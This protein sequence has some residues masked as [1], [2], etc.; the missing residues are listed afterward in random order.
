[1]S[2]KKVEIGSYT[3]DIGNAKKRLD[4]LD[5]DKMMIQL[6]D[7][8]KMKAQQF[9]DLFDIETMLWGGSC[10]GACDLPASIGDA[11]VLLHVGHAEI[12]NLESDHPVIYLE[13]RMTRWKSLPDDIFEKGKGRI[14]LYAPVQ[15]LHHLD[16]AVEEIENEKAGFEAVVREG[17]DRIKYPGQVLGCNYTVGVEDAEHHLYIGT[18]RFHPLGLSF[19]LKDDVMV[20]NPVTG[21]LSEIGK[22]ERDD[23]LRKRFARIPRV[24]D[25]EKVMIITSTKEGQK[26]N[27]LSEKTKQLGEKAG[28]KTDMITFDEIEP[29][30]VDDFGWDCAVCTACPRIA[31]DDH[32][33][34]RTTILSPI[35]FEIGINK[36]RIEVDDWEMDEISGDR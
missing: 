6:P 24:K 15:H 7:G 32:D 3:F 14:A 10:Y 13:G 30:L 25:A 20:Y 9:Q 8:L 17:D 1:M 4:E 5:P 19:S 12:P 22:K 11:D 18:G 28:K 26:R 27:T 35:E 36:G 29:D 34:F 16:K 23:F 33:R 2:C 31:L 21:E